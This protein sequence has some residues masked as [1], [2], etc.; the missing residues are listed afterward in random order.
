MLLRMAAVA[1]PYQASEK[2]DSPVIYPMFAMVLL[3]FVVLTKLFRSRVRAV[4]EGK[5]S[6]AYFRIYQGE[7]EPESTAKPSRH[8]ANP[9]EAPVLF[10]VV[11]L[12]AM[13]THFTGVAMQVLAWTYVGARIMHAYVHLGGNRIRK[14]IRAYFFSWIILLAMWIYLVAGVSLGI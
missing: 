7:V 2:K 4:R 14:R 3:T 12:A 13:I 6:A 10:Y 1:V 5:V 9:F 11:C 8:F